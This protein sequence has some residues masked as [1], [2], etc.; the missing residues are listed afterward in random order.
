MPSVYIETT[1]P[2]FYYTSRKSLTAMLWRDETVRW[3][4]R[5]RPRYTLYT[6][7][8]VTAELAASRLHTEQRLALLAEA[9]RLDVREETIDIAKEYIRSG[10]MPNGLFGDAMH[11][12]LASYYRMDFLLT[13]NCRH[14]ANA[15]KFRYLEAV[16]RRL[17]LHVPLLVT[18]YNLGSEG[19][20]GTQGTDKHGTA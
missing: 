7:T 16:N 12:A 8:A 3:W 6:S 4:T 15:N 13:W 19:P 11:V 14:L 18:P 20:H 17:A 1:I 2:S 5:D 9:I 10:L